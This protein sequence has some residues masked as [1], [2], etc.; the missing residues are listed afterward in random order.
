MFV[1]VWVTVWV[2]EQVCEWVNGQGGWVSEY[3]HELVCSVFWL[4]WFNA[5]VIF[6]A[7]L[8]SQSS[9]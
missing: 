3:E 7:A 9:V 1:C 2:S 8:V 4:G 5:M 6:R